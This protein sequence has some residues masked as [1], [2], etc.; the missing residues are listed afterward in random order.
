MVRRQAWKL[1]RAYFLQSVKEMLL[2]S[3]QSNC[4]S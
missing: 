1:D 2:K 4:E 3:G